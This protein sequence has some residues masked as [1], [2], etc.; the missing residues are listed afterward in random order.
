MEICFLKCFKFYKES[1]IQIFTA[2]NNLANQRI[3]KLTKKNSELEESIQ[4]TD[5]DINNIIAKLE[6]N[7]HY[8]IN[9]V[10]QKLRDL[11]DRSRRNNL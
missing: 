8:E 6:Q 7:N 2:N 10:H 9:M 5:N 4:F 3:D 1:I 11:E